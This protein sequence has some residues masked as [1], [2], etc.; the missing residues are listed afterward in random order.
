MDNVLSVY[1]LANCCILHV[2]RPIV[3]CNIFFFPAQNTKTIDNHIVCIRRCA[4]VLQCKHQ[5]RV[6]ILWKT[7]LHRETHPTKLQQFLPLILECTKKIQRTNPTLASSEIFGRIS[8]S[9]PRKSSRKTAHPDAH[10]FSNENI[11]KHIPILR[12]T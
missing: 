4:Q 11:K 3:G 9:S 6:P 8:N 1:V 2:S 12:E 7:K 10:K 5:K